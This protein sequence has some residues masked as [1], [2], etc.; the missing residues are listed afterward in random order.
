MAIHPNVQQKAQ[1]EL[2]AVVGR[3][4]PPNP[5]ELT[6]LPYLKAVLKEVLR[7]A[8]VANLGS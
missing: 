1:A 6:D 7:F 5:R 2:D 8:P 3:D 4:K